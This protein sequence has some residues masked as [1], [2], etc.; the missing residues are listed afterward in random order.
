MKSTSMKLKQG[1][2]FVALLSLPAMASAQ[3]NE[4]LVDNGGFES[5]TGK[6]KKPGQ[7]DLATG[8]KSPTG[9]RA[10]VFLSDSKEPAIGA[11]A[12]VYGNEAPKEG[13]NYAGFLAYS[14]GNKVPRTYV[15]AKLKTPLK[16]D[17]KYCVQFYVSLA[18]GSKYAV[19]QIGMN[20]NKKEYSTAEKSA[21]IDETQVQHTDNKI[22]NAMYGWEL[23]CATYVAEGGEKYITIGNFTSDENTKNERNK[24]GDDWKGTQIIAAYYYVDDISV[25]MLGEKDVCDCGVEVDP[26]AVSSTIYQRTVKTDDK[27]MTPKDRI[28]AQALFFAFGKDALTPE[29]TAALDLIA[30]ELKANTALTVTMNGHTDAAEDE[31]AVKKPYYVDMDKKRL[32]AAKAYLVKKGI[33]DWRIKTN[34]KGSTE[35]YTTS[36]SETSSQDNTDLDDLNRAKNRRIQFTVN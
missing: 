8:W 33:E 28:E 21:I 36:G 27:K 1:V 24:K 22:F 30:A 26:N 19:N 35:K 16:K 17:V 15:L 2:F 11:P 6:I 9:A 4:N 5:T 32:A 31:Y 14:Y 20:I 18:D 23:I 3:N 10:D 12:N 29:A 7:I 13:E 34:A 25:K